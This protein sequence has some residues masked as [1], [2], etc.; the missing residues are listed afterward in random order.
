MKQKTFVYVLNK[1]GKPLMPTTRCGHVR[2]LLKEKK[3]VPVCNNPFT[4]RLKYETPDV[5]QSLYLG[6]DTGRENIGIAVSEEN[7]NCVYLAELETHNK[8]I[9]KKMTERREFRSERRR[10][11]RISKQRKAIKNGTT[12]QNGYDTVLRSKKECKSKIVIYPGMEEGITHKVIQGAEAQ[13]NNRKRK[14]NWITPSGRQLIQMHMNAIK[15]VQKILPVSHIII[16]RISFDFQKLANQNIHTW[17]YWKG[18]LYGFKDY[19][20]YIDSEQNGICLLCGK[21]HIEYYHHIVSKSNGGSDNINNIAG[22][23]YNCHYGNDGVHKNEASKQ[24]QTLKEGL[25]Q[26]YK[27]SLLNSVMPVLI[28]E[29]SEFCI[30]NNYKFSVTDGYS[31]SLTRKQMNLP[32]THC[33]DA[34]CISMANILIQC[35]ILPSAIYEQRRFKK[36]SSNLIHKRNNREYYIKEGNKLVL[37]AKNRHKAIEQNF[38]SLEEYLSEYAL[39][40]TEY[41]C[42]KHA[43]N[44]IVKPCKRTYTY[45]KEKKIAPIHPGDTV[46]YEKHNKNGTMRTEVFIVENIKMSENKA[47][48]KNNTKSKNLEFCIRITSG[49][50]CFINKKNLI[51]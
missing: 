31:T 34:Y 14:E 32:K 29:V 37:V 44:L 47:R 4:I 27:I 13:F 19:K 23:C 45:H 10:H 15:S 11:K 3:A 40:H 6:I 22:L 7:G 51:I 8:S 35:K 30:N 36:K 48:Y 5:V 41:E 18:P 12:I 21:N 39:T 1:K 38:P 26:K 17:Q 20:D 33:I 2:K 9:K 50:I 16:E 25:K 49:S 28:E 42:I 43:K 46:K 24:L